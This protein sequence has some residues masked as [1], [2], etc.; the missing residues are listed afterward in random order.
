MAFH[1]AG[2][3]HPLPGD[4]IVGIVATGRGVTIHGRDCQTLASFAATPERFIEVGWNLDA[5]GKGGAHTARISVIADHTP[6]ALADIANGLARQEGTVANLKI[7]NRQQDF[8][9][10]LVDVEV[11]DLAHLAKVIAGLRATAG[12]K[13]VERARG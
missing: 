9:E 8:I 2:C 4:P 12:I 11:R 6:G 5:A 13:S 10:V 1:F 3:C 7:T